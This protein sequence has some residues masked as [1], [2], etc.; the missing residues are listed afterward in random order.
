M[1]GEKEKL[2]KGLWERA[3]K[4]L[5]ALYGENPDVC[6]LN[7]FHSEKMTFDETDAIIVWDIVA[8]IRIEAKHNGHLT[9]LTGTDSSCFVAYLMGASDINPLPLHYRCQKCGKIEFI[10]NKRALPFDIV[11]KPCECGH[12]MHADGFDIP[13]EMHIG[14]TK[15]HLTVAS[16]VVEIADNIIKEKVHGVYSCIS[17]IKRNAS[18]SSTYVFGEKKN[19]KYPGIDLVASLDYHRAKVLSE[20]TGVDFEAVLMG[21]SEHYLS[22]PRLVSEF[23]KGNTDGVLEFDFGEHP[24]ARQLREDLKMA[25]PK[26]TYDLLKFLGALHGTRNWLYNANTLVKNGAC[27]LSDIPSHRDDV[28]MMLKEENHLDDMTALNLANKI[29]RGLKADELTDDEFILLS[30]LDLPTWFMPYIEKVIYMGA[31]SVSVGVL[32]IALAFMWYK[33]NFPDK[34]DV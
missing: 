7:R 4:T 2:K 20:S 31:K 14:R 21:I 30:N 33:M 29:S 11:D 15:S 22:D 9:N 16:A 26:T 27:Q 28:F 23:F 17:R 6:I 3:E 32:R 10:K 13:Y 12:N 34:F 8:D 24:R 25:S 19:G 18:A 5:F 1:I